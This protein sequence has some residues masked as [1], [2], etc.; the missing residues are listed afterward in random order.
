MI[1]RTGTGAAATEAAIAMQ[2]RNS[3]VFILTNF[4]QSITRFGMIAGQRGKEKCQGGIA[5]PLK[6]TNT[7]T[8]STSGKNNLNY[9]RRLLNYN[10]HPFQNVGNDKLLVLK[11]KSFS[12]FRRCQVLPS[13]MRSSIRIS[14]RPRSEK[15]QM[16]CK[17]LRLSRPR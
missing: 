14:T 9:P 12:I 16:E 7:T 1:A 17:T 15:L 8:T 10:T 4:C 11:L 6:S 13:P 3:D 5:L 2:P